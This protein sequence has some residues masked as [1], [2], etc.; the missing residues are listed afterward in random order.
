ML[1]QQILSDLKDAM[2]SGD[3][4]KRD[5]L[6]MLDSMVKNAEIEKGKRESGLNDEEIVEVLRRAIKQRKE[7]AYQYQKGGREDLS[8]KEKAEAEILSKY[9]PEQMGGEELRAVIAGAIEESGAK[10]KSGMGKV[11]GI[12]MGKVKGKAD[13]NEVRKMVEEIFNSPK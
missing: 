13:G 5:V 6:R 12:V 3:T 8:E 2:K 11:M 4:E 10:D 9:L 7:S 1:R